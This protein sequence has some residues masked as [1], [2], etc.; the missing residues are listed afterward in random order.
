M[1]INTIMDMATAMVVALKKKYY[2]EKEQSEM[3]ALF[4]EAKSFYRF[5]LTINMLTIIRATILFKFEMLLLYLKIKNY[6][7]TIF[8]THFY[9]VFN[10]Y[11]M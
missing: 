9:S 5:I 11:S 6:E 1:V 3:I 8:F 2:L 10:G 7:E 4:F